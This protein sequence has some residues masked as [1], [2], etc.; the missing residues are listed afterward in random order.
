MAVQRHQIGADG[1]GGA[2]MGGAA[3][4]RRVK[5]TRL[6]IQRHQLLVRLHAFHDDLLVQGLAKAQ[7]AAHDQRASVGALRDHEAAVDLQDVQRQVLQVGHAGVTGAEVIQRHADAL[8]VQALHA[9]RAAHRAP[10]RTPA[11]RG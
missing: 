3:C 8:L 2:G 10:A 5:S 4:R 1:Y 6:G 11:R 7:Q 9:P